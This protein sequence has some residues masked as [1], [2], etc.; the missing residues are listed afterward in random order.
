MVVWDKL[1]NQAPAASASAL[2]PLLGRAAYLSTFLPSTAP[3][4]NPLASTAAGTSGAS[5]AGDGSTAAGTSSGLGSSGP[6]TL[7]P[8]MAAAVKPALRALFLTHPVCNQRDIRSWLQTYGSTGKAASDGASSS[9]SSEVKKAAFLTDKALHEL[10]VGP[11]GKEGQGGEEYMFIRHSYVARTGNAPASEP[12][13]V[14]VLLLLT[15]KPQLKKGDIL[16]T[17]NAAGLKMS[18]TQYQK[19]MKELCRNH[20]NAWLLKQGADW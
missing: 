1:L 12:L 9:N 16:M 2:F 19:V 20:G 15:D 14:A 3:Q 17:V 10:L 6:V 18:E 8:E 4:S 5:A 11:L 13:R 7:T